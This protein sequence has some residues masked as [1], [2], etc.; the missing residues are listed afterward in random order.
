MY[1]VHAV[2]V[3][4]VVVIQEAFTKSRHVMA[5]CEYVPT[6]VC[7]NS[8]CIPMMSSVMANLMKIAPF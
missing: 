8:A 5:T 4:I 3:V 1:I 2:V 6:D 7:S